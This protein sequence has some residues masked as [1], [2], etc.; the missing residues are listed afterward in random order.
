MCGALREA[1]EAGLVHRDIK[2]ANV[3]LSFFG[4]LPDVV[5]VLDSVWS[6]RSRARVPRQA[7][8]QPSR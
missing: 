3:V 1:H 5:K 7:A 4:G 2:P 8:E 6:S